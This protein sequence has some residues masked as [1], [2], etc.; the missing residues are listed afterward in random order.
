M[1]WSMIVAELGA[2]RAKRGEARRE[3]C[4]AEAVGAGCMG[5]VSAWLVVVMVLCCGGCLHGL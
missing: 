1:T 4:D 2:S 5:A 3:V